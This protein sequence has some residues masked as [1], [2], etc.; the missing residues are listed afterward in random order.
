MDDTTGRQETATLRTLAAACG[1]QLAYR[2]MKGRTRRA[3]AEA[4][5]A[6]LRA[7]GIE[8]S[9]A[10]E[11]A[12][13]LKRVEADRRK[14]I[15]EPVIVV[16][17]GRWSRLQVQLSGPLPKGVEAELVLES[18]EIRR[19]NWNGIDR[20]VKA[21]SAAN[22]QRSRSARLPLK[23]RLP[24]GYHRLTVS[25][26]KLKATSLIIAAP[27]HVFT[28]AGS[29]RRWGLFCPLYALHSAGSWGAG[30]ISDFLRLAEWSA[31]L[32]GSVVAT[33]PLLPAFFKE[34]FNPSP[35]SPVSRLFWNEFYIEL[36]SVPE[37][38]ACP[39]AVALTTSGDYACELEG[40]RKAP[41]VDYGRQM[42]LKR[43]VLELLTESFF[44]QKDEKRSQAYAD[45]LASRPELEDYARF[46]AFSE[47]R[48]APWRD[49]P[50]KLRDGNLGEADCQPELLR[51]YLYTQFIA[52]EQM[53][54]TTARARETGQAFYLDLPLGVHPD[55]YDAW[56]EQKIFAR[57]SSVG[58]PPDP[59]FPCG[60]NWGFPPL[61]PERLRQSGY[62]YVINV[63]RHHL[64]FAGI[65]RLDHI[66]GL[67]RLF[68]IPTGLAAGD[69]VYV[70]YQPEEM[71]AILC[72]EAHRERAVI[73]GEDL[74]LV[75]AAVRRAM[76]RHHI[77]RSYV[78]QYE[79]LTEDDHCLDAVPPDAVAAVNTHDMH[80][81][82]AYWQG[83]DIAERQDVGVLRPEQAAA[84]TRQRRTGKASLIRCL[85]KHGRV[86]SSEPSVEEAYR[87]ICRLLADSDAETFLLNIDD[88]WGSMRAQNIPGTYAEHPNWQRRAG[89]SLEQFQADPGIEA[90]LREIDRRRKETNT[91]S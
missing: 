77:Y 33:L 50:E 59:A 72:L 29:P 19:Y 11:A 73:V 51:Y 78:G 40:L 52:H 81:F 75:P 68:W 21:E 25:A 2:D 57:T 10:S 9:G 55:G 39:E 31:L 89:K 53:A 90:F 61:H 28:P 65:L 80:P 58:A 46:R 3:S 69:G 15:V 38:A 23:E 34:H 49:W 47:E 36:E 24:W 60:Q 5:L 86:A 32:G 20:Y 6:A 91:K 70:R 7:L 45:Y 18:G 62:R 76:R 43:R 67:H 35:Y 8:I 16:W 48:K 42:S 74:G 63:L 1:I 79:M 88:L 64:R 54:D 12:P 22:D 13:A 66:M 71:Y 82:A 17:E 44:R 56:R 27:R 14:R 84:E 83:T 4:L 85:H 41:M 26:G 87:A 37:L 30:D